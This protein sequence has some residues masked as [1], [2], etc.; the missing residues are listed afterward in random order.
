ML[1]ALDRHLEFQYTDTIRQV[2]ARNYLYLAATARLNGKRAETAKHFVR[3]IRN[4][5]W[6]LPGGKRPLAGLAAYTLI[7]SWY[8]ILSRG[9]RIK[10][11]PVT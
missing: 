7:G 2:I 4:G 6:W 3:C 5:V 8:K 1:K 11:S 9:E 10:Q